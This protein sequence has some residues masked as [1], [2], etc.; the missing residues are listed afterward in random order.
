MK[1]ALQ[2]VILGLCFSS[3]LAAQEIRLGWG[4]HPTLR[5]GN[6]LRVDF[7]A[8]FQGDMRRSAAMAAAEDDD[9]G[10]ALDIAKRRVG[11]E[12][13]VARL[14][15]YQLDYELGV[16]E[17]RDVYLDYRQFKALQVRAGKFKLPFGLDENTSATGLDFVYRS[18]ISARLAPGR[19]RG[20]AA[21]GRVFSDRISYEAGVFKNDGD[22]ARPSNSARVFGA[23]TTAVRLV[24]VPF[25]GS[26][27]ALADFQAGVAFSGTTVPYGFSSIRA[28]TV[29]GAS[30]F[31]SNVWVNGR[32]QRTG[33]EMRWRPGSLSVQAEYIRLTDERRGESVEDSDLPPLP[34]E[35]WY[36]SGTYAVTG[37]TKSVGLDTPRYRFGAVELAARLEQLRFGST[38]ARNDL[39]T[40][41]RAETVLGNSDRAL[42]LGA[43]WYLNRWMKIQANLIREQL[44][45]PSMGPLPRH[46]SFWSRVL[47]FQFTV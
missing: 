43:N 23:R 36:V 29:L 11:I 40:S 1:R 6:W 7:R 20:V 16:R 3:P 27:S 21:H 28:R 13:R 25:R 46:A 34:A 15:D 24:L 4:D 33:L 44:H 22:N 18:R 31:E 37:E 12:G 5:A 26:K 41:R 9:P 35:G 19:D 8:R 2:A 45:D 38:A 30:F 14:V 10:G 32:R 42:T 47:R 39:S 17:W